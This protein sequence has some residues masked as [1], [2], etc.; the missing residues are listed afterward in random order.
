[1]A[2]AHFQLGIEYGLLP[3]YDEA[4]PELERAIELYHNRDSLPMWIVATLIWVV[5]RF[6]PRTGKIICFAHDPLGEL[7]AEKALQPDM[8]LLF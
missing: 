4:I 8:L 6:F 5:A 2:F 7:H 1:M 3:Q